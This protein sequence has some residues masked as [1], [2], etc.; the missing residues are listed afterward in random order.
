MPNAIKINLPRPSDELIKTVQTYAD[1][2]Q[3]DPDKK[4]WLDEFHSNKI[5][6]ALHYFDSPDFLTQLFQK[7]F[8]DF[9]PHHKVG[10]MMGLMKNIQ[11]IPACMPPHCDRSRAFGL[12]YFITLGGNNV[13]T[14]FYDK[15]IPI[16]GVATNIPYTEINPIE[17]YVASQGWYGYNVQRC[18]S[19]ENIDTTRL[20][21]AIRLV[22]IGLEDDKDFEYTM[23]DFQL[24]YP[25]LCVRD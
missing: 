9:F 13:K 18:H 2:Y 1:S 19:V 3:F 24:D 20:Y 25:H 10:G 16:V 22:R 5:N 21:I 12:N 15:I 8:Q 11:N 7:E 23:S 17:E 4:R 14:V 6:S